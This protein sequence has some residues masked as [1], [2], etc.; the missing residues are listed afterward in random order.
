[1]QPIDAGPV[2]RNLKLLGKAEVAGNHCRIVKRHLVIHELSPEGYLYS[3]KSEFRGQRYS[4]RVCA[5]VQV[6]VSHTNAQHLLSGVGQPRAYAHS[7]GGTYKFTAGNLEQQKPLGR[8]IHETLLWFTPRH[9]N[10]GVRV[11]NY[12]A[13]ERT[14]HSLSGVA[15]AL[16]QI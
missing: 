7:N 4:L 10:L 15:P 9:S 5:Q 3:L 8:A 6:P 13:G 16:A 11:D 12:N 2:D 1:V 14:C